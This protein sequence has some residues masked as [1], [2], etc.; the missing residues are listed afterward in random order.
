MIVGLFRLVRR[1]FPR[2]PVFD[3]EGDEVIVWMH[4][5]QRAA[6]RES[7][8]VRVRLVLRDRIIPPERAE[9]PSR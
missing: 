8:R 9:G 4:D 6:E 1:L 7:E 3:P 5:Q 2:R